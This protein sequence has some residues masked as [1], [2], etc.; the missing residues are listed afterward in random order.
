[1]KKS[2]AP[3]RQKPPL[4][5][6]QERM[7]KLASKLDS[8]AAGAE[9]WLRGCFRFGKPKITQ[10]SWEGFWFV[11]ADRPKAVHYCSWEDYRQDKPPVL[12]S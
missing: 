8:R 6:R 5:Q 4:I 2:K 11:F 10:T 1:M 3:K 9:K 12:G 7:E